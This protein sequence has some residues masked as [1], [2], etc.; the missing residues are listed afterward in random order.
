MSVRFS[1]T[2]CTDLQKHLLSLL[3]SSQTL[4]G[5]QLP[6][7]PFFLAYSYNISVS[8]SSKV[9]LDSCDMV[10]KSLGRALKHKVTFTMLLKA[11]IRGF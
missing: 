8:N 2:K 6:L 11:L 9:H 4:P 5:A 3:K 7:I 1:I 10:N